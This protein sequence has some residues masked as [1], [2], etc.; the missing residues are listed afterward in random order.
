MTGHTG[1]MPGSQTSA[2]GGG[3]TAAE[4]SH[5]GTVSD[6]E[7]VE[8]VLQASRAMVSLAEASVRHVS[9]DVTIAQYR[10]LVV[11]ATTGP[12]RLGTLAQT[13]GVNPSTTTRMC[14]RL[15]RKGLMTRSRDR[16]DRRETELALTESGRRLVTDVTASRRSIVESVLDVI[17]ADERRGLVRSL[18]LLARVVSEAP[19]PHWAS[20]WPSLD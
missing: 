5:P 14:D 13:I 6:D 4:E 17:P 12:C 11:L 1:L 8:A 20:G 10:T 3:G 19:E 18:K 9:D 15:V 2:H 16:L 7:V